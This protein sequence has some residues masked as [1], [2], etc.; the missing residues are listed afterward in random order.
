MGRPSLLLGNWFEACAYS[1]AQLATACDRQ[2]R[3]QVL[4]VLLAIA[5][6]AKAYTKVVSGRR[7]NFQFRITCKQRG[8]SVEVIARVILSVT[9]SI[10]RRVV[11]AS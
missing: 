11:A 7:L 10:L 3:T 6:P 5:V 1:G 8:R 9:V 4:V 2:Q